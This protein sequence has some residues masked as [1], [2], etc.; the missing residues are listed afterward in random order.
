MTNWVGGADKKCC[1][2]GKSLHFILLTISHEYD[3]C[4][5]V[6]KSPISSGHKNNTEFL[7][8]SS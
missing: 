2:L 8:L 1:I 7:C 3:S 6:P 5:A 4:R